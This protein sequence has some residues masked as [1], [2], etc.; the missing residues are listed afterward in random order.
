MARC[1]WHGHPR[2]W[3]PGPRLVTRYAHRCLRGGPCRSNAGTIVSS[4][5]L[6]PLVPR[7]ISLATAKRCGRSP[8][9]PNACR[10]A[11]ATPELTAFTTWQQVVEYAEDDP[12][13]TDLAVAVRMIEKYGP[14][15]V[16]RAI[17]GTVRDIRA[18]CASPRPTRARDSNGV[19]CGSATTTGTVGQANRPAVADTPRGRH[20]RLRG[21]DPG[22]GHSR[23]YRPG[24]GPRPPRSPR[25]PAR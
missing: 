13:G 9:P 20:A 16:I 3:Q 25:H 4:S 18:E 7:C 5:P 6:T 14:D 23:Q 2:S 19:G 21:C 1:R 15:E 12:A 11:P 17:D 22:R 10:T 8:R 24:L